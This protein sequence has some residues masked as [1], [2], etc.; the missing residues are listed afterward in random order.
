MYC[1]TFRRK[2]VRVGSQ[3][4]VT[5]VTGPRPRFMPEQP[6]L[7]VHYPRIST[8]TLLKRSALISPTLITIVDFDMIRGSDVVRRV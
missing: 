8:I 1:L 7:P 5:V 4:D 3:L 6:G 2:D